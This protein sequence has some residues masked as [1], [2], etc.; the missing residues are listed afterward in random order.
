MYQFTFPQS[1]LKS[2]L[3]SLFYFFKC[4]ICL[5]SMPDEVEN[6]SRGEC[7]S[8]LRESLSLLRLLSSLSALCRLCSLSALQWGQKKQKKNTLCC[9][10]QQ[11]SAEKPTHTES[12]ERDTHTAERETHTHTAERDTHTQQRESKESES[13]RRAPHRSHLS[14]L[15]HPHTLYVYCCVHAVYTVIKKK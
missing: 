12:G 8:H 6:H 9:T 5:T 1:S 14:A 10:T 13:K 2:E 3:S 7:R 11:L 15:H 4:T